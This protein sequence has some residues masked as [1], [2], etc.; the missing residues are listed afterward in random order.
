MQQTASER[1]ER[2][3]QDVA[4]FRVQNLEQNNNSSY[5]RYHNR[6]HT[7][8]VERAE[9]TSEGE[10]PLDGIEMRTCVRGTSPDEPCYRNLLLID[11]D[12]HIFQGEANFKRR[13]LDPI[14]HSTEEFPKGSGRYDDEVVIRGT[15]P[16][17]NEEILFNQLQRTLSEVQRHPERFPEEFAHFDLN[18]YEG[19]HI[20]NQHDRQLIDTLLPENTGEKTF[21]PPD[22]GYAII[23][24]GETV[25]AKFVLAARLGKDISQIRIE[26]SYDEMGKQKYDITYHFRPRDEQAEHRHDGKIVVNERSGTPYVVNGRDELYA[27][28]RQ[29]GSYRP[30]DQ[31]E[32]QGY[33]Q[34]AR[35]QVEHFRIAQNHEAFTWW[36]NQLQAVYQAYG[37]QQRR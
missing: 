20:T 11:G 35:S 36:S 1:G 26:K 34:Q 5:Q 9:P 23:A 24:G 29:Y 4:R 18:T 28:T 32:V 2:R 14:E 37:I 30:A 17:A 19:L 31:R 27:M 13:P 12:R 25:K 6:Y 16:L 7:H 15:E 8:W 33:I 3:I 22:R 10:E 21:S